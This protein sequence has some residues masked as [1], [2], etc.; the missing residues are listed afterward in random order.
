MYPTYDRQIEIGVGFEFG[1]TEPNHAR[2]FSFPSDP[3]SEEGSPGVV[4]S[5]CPTTTAQRAASLA[6][7]PAGLPQRGQPEGPGRRGTL[8]W[9]LS[10]RA[11]RKYLACRGETRRGRGGEVSKSARARRRFEGVVRQAHH[12]RLANQRR[13]S[14]ASTPTAFPTPLS[15]CSDTQACPGYRCSGPA[16]GRGRHSPYRGSGAGWCSRN[17]G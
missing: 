1:F 12:E 4:R 2:C 15:P 6:T 3:P 7:G 14:V 11:T 5:R 17:A 10:C 16:R 9:V 13:A 8:L